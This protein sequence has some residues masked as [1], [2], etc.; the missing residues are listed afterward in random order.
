[1][2]AHI[3][4]HPAWFHRFGAVWTPTVLLLDSEGIE[5]VRL[6]GY[7]PNE[8][9]KASLE[10]GLARI[11]FVNKQYADAVRWYNRVV[12][13][14]PDSHLAAEAMFWRAVV[15]YKASNDHT[16]LG[17]AAEDLQVTYPSSLWTAKASPWL[18]QA[19]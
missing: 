14:Y 17:K 7:L 11:A 16:V 6:E 2:K 1:V 4:E 10:N 18:P 13:E 19:S 3:K 8:D 15:H 12:K 9:F 5:Q